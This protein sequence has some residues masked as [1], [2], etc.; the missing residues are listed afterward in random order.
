MSRKD[1]LKKIKSGVLSRGLAL[2]KVSVSA[3]AKAATHA[4]GNLFADEASKPERLKALLVS[5][6][7][8]LSQELGQLKGSMMKV[9]QLISMYGEHFLPPEANALLKS[10]QAQSPPLE[11]KAIEKVI[12]KQITPELLEDLEIDPVP[13]ASASLGQVHRALRKSTGQWLAMKIQYPGVDQAIEGDLK[14]LKSIL[15]I[16]KLIPK[17]PNYDEVFHEIK[18]MLYQEVD[19]EREFKTTVEFREKL[20]GDSF[21]IIPEPIA[22]FS[23][24][25]ILTTT[26]EEGVAVDSAEV[27]G[28][29]QERRDAIGAAALMLYMRELFEFAAVQTDPHFGNYRVR[30]GKD[31]QPDRLVLLDFGAVRKLSKS[32]LSAYLE[33]V[34][35]AHAQDPDRLIEA[36]IR[37]GYL[38]EDDGESLQRVFAELCL[39]ITEPFCPPPTPGAP[40]H[41][42]DSN[43]GYHWELSDLPQRVAKKGGQL[44]LEAR[45]RNPPREIVFLDRKLGG[46]FIFL[47]VLRVRFNARDLAKPFVQG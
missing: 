2:A 1:S 43:G 8:T 45:L 40:A 27:L 44:A 5:Q 37:L 46:I 13:V 42:F 32:F 22:E 21:Y 14:A 10:L 16:S 23:T 38:N 15:Q 47:S 41:F 18:S 9:G 26:F 34:K 3:G 39:L 30:I 31:G 25:R 29:P 24:G 20:S 6:M 7:E 19:Y 4:V 17:G 28:L 11:W 12:R 33:M 35:A 36:G